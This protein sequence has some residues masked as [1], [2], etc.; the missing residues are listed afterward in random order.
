MKRLFLTVCCLV[1][2]VT[3]VAAAT[4]RK[5]KTVTNNN[6]YQILVI[7]DTHLLAPELYDDGEAAQKLARNDMKLV[8]QSDELMS[9]TVNWVIKQKPDLLLITGDLTF[10]GEQ[11]S[12]KRLATHLAR[13]AQNGVPTLVIPG[14]HDISN[15]NAKQYK[16]DKATTAS[17]ITRDE[18]AQIYAPYG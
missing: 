7:S 12:H 5:K 14:N 11:A 6:P 8:L 16:G 9:A 13:L 2:V 10:N 4:P 15:P 3:L 18:L 1:A 17:T